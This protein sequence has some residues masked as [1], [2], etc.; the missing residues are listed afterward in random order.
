MDRKRAAMQ[1]GKQQEQKRQNEADRSREKQPDHV[2]NHVDLK[3]TAPLT[4]EKKLEIERAKQQK[5]PAPAPRPQPAVDLG[6]PSLQEKPLPA[7][8][9]YRGE[10]GQARPASR[11]ES[12]IHQPDNEFSRSVNSTFQNTT[13]APPKRP[14]QQEAGDDSQSRPTLQRNGPSNHGPEP[15]RRKTIEDND[16]DMADS[17]SKGHMAPPMRQSSMR[18]KVSA[19]HSRYI[20]SIMLTIFV[21][22]AYE[23][24]IP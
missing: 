4:A 16:E 22:W 20:V 12:T 13:K 21:G 18:P 1:E 15:K 23:V 8:P 7:A 14:L 6:Q 3:K 9:T 11:M 10:L 2:A 17:Q 5:P 24:S 19:V